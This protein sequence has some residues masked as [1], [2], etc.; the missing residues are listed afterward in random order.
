MK[1][2]HDMDITFWLQIVLLSIFMLVLAFERSP[3]E[4]QIEPLPIVKNKARK[5]GV[6]IRGVT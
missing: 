4:E 1:S 2:T 3:V 6:E 5:S